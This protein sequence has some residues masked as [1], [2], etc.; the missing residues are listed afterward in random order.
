MQ[1]IYLFIIKPRA[2]DL[3]G[4]NSYLTQYLHPNSNVVSTPPPP[5]LP[6]TR[7]SHLSFSLTQ[8]T[9]PNRYLQNKTTNK[10]CGFAV[11][12]TSQNSQRSFSDLYHQVVWKKILGES[13]SFSNFFKE[14]VASKF[15]TYSPKSLLRSYGCWE[16]K[17]SVH[18]CVCVCE[19]EREREREREWVR[20]F[21]SCVPA[22]VFM[23]DV[24][25]VPI[26]QPKLS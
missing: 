9:T 1:C 24:D 23:L 2:A 11:E 18:M 5:P 3:A 6:Q 15:E 16:V 19:R 4:T 14:L 26:Y 20:E 21:C 13:E 10:N 25:G 8:I 22:C 7:N 17:L 12:I